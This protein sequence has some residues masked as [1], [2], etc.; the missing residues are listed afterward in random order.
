M[1]TARPYP[2]TMHQEVDPLETHI[3][4]ARQR[5]RGRNRARMLVITAVDTLAW[6][7]TT[8]ALAALIGDSASLQIVSAIAFTALWFVAVRIW[9]PRA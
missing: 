7:V 6:L 1:D 5:E 4:P 3:P 8:A 9:T 2:A